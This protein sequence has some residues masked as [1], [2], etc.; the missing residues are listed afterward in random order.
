VS[1][2]RSLKKINNEWIK[3]RQGDQEAQLRGI[4]DILDPVLVHYFDVVEKEY[5][6]SKIS[7]D[8]RSSLLKSEEKKVG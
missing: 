2:N 5:I 3:D 1:T 8:R 7:F 4:M 6:Y